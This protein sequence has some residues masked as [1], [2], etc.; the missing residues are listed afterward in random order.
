[1]VSERKVNQ[2]DCKPFENDIYVFIFVFVFV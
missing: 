1:M 2:V